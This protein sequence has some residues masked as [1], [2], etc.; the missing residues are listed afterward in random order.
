MRK[1]EALPG[2]F[3]LF[4]STAQFFTFLRFSWEL[5]CVCYLDPRALVSLVKGW[6]KRGNTVISVTEPVNS[7]RRAPEEGE[8]H[9]EASGAGEGG[10]S[11]PWFCGS[12]G[13]KALEC[14][15]Y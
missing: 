5:F 7:G 13:G 4:F 8:G 9:P 14:T 1:T 12:P 2:D 15:G 6:M 11:T 10:L 3:S